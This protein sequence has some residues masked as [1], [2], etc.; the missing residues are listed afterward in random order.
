MPPAVIE[1]RWLSR[2][3]E[4]PTGAGQ[5]G[6][7]DTRLRDELPEELLKPLGNL[8]K[9]TFSRC[10]RCGGCWAG[11]PSALI[12]AH[13]A[14][15]T[16]RCALQRAASRARFDAR[17]VAGRYMDA[18]AAS[19]AQSGHSSRCRAQ[20]G[21]S[22]RCRATSGRFRAFERTK[23]AREVRRWRKPARERGE[24]LKYA[25]KRIN[26]LNLA[27]K[28]P[29]NKPDNTS[30][31]TKTRPTRNG[32][33]PAAPLYRPNRSKKSS[34]FLPQSASVTSAPKR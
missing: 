10:M 1:P 20:S 24:R 26:R 2:H 21:H 32:P 30:K 25:R 13:G 6:R 7:Y 5:Y 14:D 27:R 8:R 3:D 4:S 29:T 33:A 12:P 18:R 15:G 22:L 9:S 19:R 17:A 16:S 34:A 28:T 31:T 11:S 23:A